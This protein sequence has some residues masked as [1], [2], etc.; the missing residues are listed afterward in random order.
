M[1]ILFA[2][3]LTLVSIT[4]N[5][6]EA[7]PMGIFEIQK[8]GSGQ[9]NNHSNSP[10]IEISC[11]GCLSPQSGRPRSN[12]VRPHINNGRVIGGYWRS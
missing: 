10:L 7:K 4:F 6:V 5:Q 11:F 3:A 9:I 12:Y 2:I 1:K 8:S